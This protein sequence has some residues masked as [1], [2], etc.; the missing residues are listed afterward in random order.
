MAKKKSGA[1]IE[2]LKKNKKLKKWVKLTHRTLGFVYHNSMSLPRKVGFDSSSSLRDTSVCGILPRF[3]DVT[4][5]VMFMS[6]LVGCLRS[7]KFK[8]VI[9]VSLEF[10]RETFASGSLI[11]AYFS[12]SNAQTPLLFG[13]FQDIPSYLFSFSG[14][15]MYLCPEM[16]I[17]YSNWRILHKVSHQLLF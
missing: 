16:S 17:F 14:L 8:S 9:F 2:N 5:Y 10:H 6:G 11:F 13:I 12:H 1:R 4:D 15:V 7:K 3:R